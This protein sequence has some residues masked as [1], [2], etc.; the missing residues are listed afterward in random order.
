[1]EDQHDYED[2]YSEEDK[3]HKKHSPDAIRTSE[4]RAFRDFFRWEIS[5]WL[6]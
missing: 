5:S 3:D 2:D 1:M 4:V 6:N